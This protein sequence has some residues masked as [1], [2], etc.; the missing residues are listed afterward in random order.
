MS[1]IAELK[2]LPENKEQIK[3]FV[4]AVKNELLN[5]EIEPLQLDYRLK[6]IEEMIKGIR[7]DSEI[8]ELTYDEATK[9]GK[10]IDFDHCEIRLSEKKTYDFKQDHVIQDLEMKLK[11]RKQLLKSVTGNTIVYDE[12]GAQLQPL[13]YKTTNIITYKLK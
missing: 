9:Y 8:K 5:G 2:R 7:K 12:Q 6:V 11:A 4:A 13:P 3:T 1:A 10:T